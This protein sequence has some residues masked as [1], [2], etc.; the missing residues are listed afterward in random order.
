MRES[1]W[2]PFEVVSPVS[3]VSSGFVKE[4]RSVARTGKTS[5]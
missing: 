3:H 5:L 1:P 4:R 2:H